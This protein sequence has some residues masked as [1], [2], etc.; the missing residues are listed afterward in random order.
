MLIGSGCL[1]ILGQSQR[2]LRLISTVEL[3]RNRLASEKL[4]RFN[5]MLG[6][7]SAAGDFHGAERILQRAVKS[8]VAPDTL[9]FALVVAASAE[10]RDVV[11]AEM[12]LRRLCLTGHAAAACHPEVIS[13]LMDAGAS[14]LARVA[15]QQEGSKDDGDDTTEQAAE[16]RL[17]SLLH[18]L[19][20]QSDL[21]EREMAAIR[22]LWEEVLEQHRSDGLVP[23]RRTLRAMLQVLSR[24]SRHYEI[25]TLLKEM[26]SV[27]FR[28]DSETFGALI[29]GAS[30]RKDVAQ[31]EAF[32]K[33]A[34]EN[35]IEP[36]LPMLNSLIKGCAAAAD[37]AS[38]KKWYHRIYSEGL[39]P[40]ILSFNSF[41]GA[42]GTAGYEQEAESVLQDMLTAQLRPDGFSYLALIKAHGHK[43]AKEAER[44]FSV[45]LSARVNVDTGMFNAVLRAYV[46]HSDPWEVKRLY[47][48]MQ[49]RRVPA[50]A[51]TFLSVAHAYAVE[52]E[53]SKAEDLIYASQEAGYKLGSEEFSC[54][55]LAYSWKPQY[56]SHKAERLFREMISE[57]K[58]LP[59]SRMLRY[60]RLAMGE[61][62]AEALI[63]ELGVSVSEAESSRA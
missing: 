41:L 13:S 48:D 51:A 60:L 2:Q 25:G 16:T 54:L 24:C 30:E 10:A 9:S 6:V 43:S 27:G 58:I 15:A 20:K 14:E 45:A 23:S 21:S 11:R 12:W 26:S 34:R 5:R 53:V 44:W 50:N 8:E 37:V 57:R 38:A 47:A 55:L 36:T 35:G 7:C 40:S 17:S 63:E 56:R 3:R 39:T 61:A 49:R 29:D 1:S 52:G 31:A 62:P 19:R 32:F 22:R 28:A 42:C 33:Q 59:T 46:V 18:V 4:T